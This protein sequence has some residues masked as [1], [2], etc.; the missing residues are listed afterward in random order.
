LKRHT[1]DRDTSI[2]PVQPGDLSC[3]TPEFGRVKDIERLYGIKRGC[4][5]NLL[6]DGKVKGVL[7]RVRGQK[8]GVRLFDLASVREYIRHCQVQQ[9][10]LVRPA[11]RG[12][13]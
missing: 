1:Q 8:S 3:A 10:G 2:E 6:A 13:P 9:G 11:A 4:L 12:S 5:Y 7:L